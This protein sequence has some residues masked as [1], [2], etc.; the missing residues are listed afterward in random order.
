MVDGFLSKAITEL[1]GLP[2]QVSWQSMPD[3]RG[4]AW[5]D[6]ESY[7]IALH[8]KMRGDKMQSAAV[9]LHEAGNIKAGHVSMAAARRRGYKHDPT[10]GTPDTFDEKWLNREFAAWD[11]A[12]EWADKI[13]EPDIVSYC[14]SQRMSDFWRYVYSELQKIEQRLAALGWGR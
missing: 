13:G 10:I 8:T 9:V 7:G 4:K 12:I 6:P 5:A 1:V 2:V 3:A 14:K 11:A